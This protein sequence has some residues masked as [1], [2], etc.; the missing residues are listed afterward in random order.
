MIEADSDSNDH[1]ERIERKIQRAYPDIK[2]PKEMNR[3][4]RM[5]S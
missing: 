4:R 3:K 5:V 2:M 1:F